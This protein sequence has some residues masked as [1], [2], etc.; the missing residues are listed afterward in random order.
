MRSHRLRRHPGVALLC[1]AL[2]VGTVL[3]C[4]D[5]DPPAPPTTTAPSSSSTTPSSTAPATTAGPEDDEAA[6]RRLAEE[7][8]EVARQLYA[9]DSDT[10]QI[11]IYLVARYL[12]GFAT[13]LEAFRMSGRKAELSQLSQH[14][15]ESL[16]IDGDSASLVE[17]VVDA[18]LLIDEDGNVLNND[19]T[20]KRY[21][22]TA[23]RT[24]SGW[25]LS[26]RIKVAES[27]GESC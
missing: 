21:E 4:G 6:L 25:R 5:D 23:T 2:V 11:A 17:C 10:D 15:V 26:D 14:V 16:S 13:Q 3:G 19:A 24:E 20:K 12:D 9:G 7:W 18:D 1:V 8:F 22:T 27:D